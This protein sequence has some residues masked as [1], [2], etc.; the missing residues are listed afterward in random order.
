MAICFCRSLWERQGCALQGMR[1][2]T[3]FGLAMT[4]FGGWTQLFGLGR[5]PTGS[6]GSVTPPYRASGR[7]KPPH[8]K[9][10]RLVME[11][12]ALLWN[13]GLPPHYK[14]SGY[15]Q[16]IDARQNELPAAARRITCR[17]AP[18]PERGGRS[19]TGSS[20]APRD[21]RCRWSHQRSCR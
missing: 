9:M 17:R 14:S 5:C 13:V 2:A 15:V 12:C 20:A 6:A 11:L 1:I 4:Q 19:R 21:P 16:L 3:P 10:G 18:C 7:K 8:P